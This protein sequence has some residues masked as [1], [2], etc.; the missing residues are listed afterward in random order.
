MERAVD[1][2][3]PATMLTTQYRMHPAI[4]RVVSRVF[5]E[6]RLVTAPEVQARRSVSRACR[7][8]HVGGQEVHHHMAGYSNKEEAKR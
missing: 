8:V 6:G 1:E 5:Y 4:C 7:L 3:V 2:G